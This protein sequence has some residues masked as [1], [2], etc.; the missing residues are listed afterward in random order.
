VGGNREI[1]IDAAL[2]PEK[3]LARRREI[4]SV[5]STETA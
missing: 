3:R 4:W 5:R 1:E 2:A